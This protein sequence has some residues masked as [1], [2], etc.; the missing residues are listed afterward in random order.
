MSKVIKTIGDYTITERDIDAF[1]A[2]LPK[3]Q[4][5]YKTIPDF[6]DQVCERLEEIT[7]FAMLG[8]ETNVCET[9]EFKAAIKDARRDIAGQI[10]MQ[11]TLKDIDVTDDEVKEFFEA[12]KAKFAKGP[13]ASAKHILVDTEE[14]AS[15][16]KKMIEAGEKSFEEA[17]KEFSTCPSGKEGGSLGKFGRG[18]MVKEFDTVVFE[19]ELNVIHGPVETQF[20]Y[21]LIWIDERNDGEIPSFD[22]ISTKVR[23]TLMH[24]KQQKAYDAQ[25]A[26]LR[27]KYIQ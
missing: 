14:K 3:E 24:E 25:L 5:M 2:T 6:R 15:D 23:A 11:N 16:I 20:G 27:E 18:Q 19:N 22:E 9:E 21:H 7:L 26:K 17:A 1:I 13:S 10:A 4:Q 8:E 12:N